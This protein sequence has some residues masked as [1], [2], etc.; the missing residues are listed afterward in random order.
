[1]EQ[2]EDIATFLRVLKQKERRITYTEHAILRARARD[3]IRDDECKVAIFESDL[4]GSIPHIIVEQYSENPAEQKFKLYYRYPEGGFV[5]YVISMD[6]EI[7]LITV[8]KVSR[9]LQKKIYKIMKR[10]DYL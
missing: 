1:M 8:Y 7:R 5:A 6:G 3:I 2:I 9:S 4:A 10:G